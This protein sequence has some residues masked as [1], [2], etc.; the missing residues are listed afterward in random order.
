MANDDNPVTTLERYS[1]SI[2][3]TNLRD[4]ADRFSQ[5]DILKAV[6]WSQTEIGAALVRLRAEFD[7]VEKP[8]LLSHSEMVRL[9]L[10][11][12]SDKKDAKERLKEKECKAQVEA[13]R[14]MRNERTLFMGKL[15]TLPK[16]VD[17]VAVMCGRARIQNPRAVAALL[18]GYWL[19]QLCKVC[20]GL[21]AAVI[22]DAPALSGKQCFKCCGTG[23]SLSPHGESG[24]KIL[25]AMDIA[26]SMAKSEIQGKMQ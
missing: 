11:Q 2:N 4:E 7:G 25:K 23:L 20:H 18:V 22:E 12:H 24:K 5:T 13:K 14:W 15:K 1:I 16:T 8:R 26:E 3:S 6:A 21:K 9:V 19:D 17:A 10:I